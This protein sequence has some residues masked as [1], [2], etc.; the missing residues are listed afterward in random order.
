[1][2]KQRLIFVHGGQGCG[3]STVT[4]SL[5]ENLTHTTLMRLAGV[6]S[7]QSDANNC[8]FKY[9]LA[10][11]QSVQLSTQTGMNFVFDRSFLCEKV[12]AN[13][14]F[15][16]HSF[17]HETEE[18]NRF[19]DSEGH[20]RDIVQMRALEA[21]IKLL[22]GQWRYQVFLK[23]YFKGDLD[24]VFE[25]MQALADAAP[26]GVRAEMEVNPSSLF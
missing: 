12:Y 5:R 6:P 9:H 17:E 19:I 4:N 25:K 7:N 21:P 10:M 23:M 3:K 18:L 16:T 1:M 8:A 26:E 14:G 2:K 22:R 11:L 15:K 24:G 20:R 13:L